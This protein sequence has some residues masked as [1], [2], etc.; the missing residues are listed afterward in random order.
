MDEKR[1]KVGCALSRMS[2]SRGDLN[3][4]LRGMGPHSGDLERGN[5]PEKND[6]TKVWLGFVIRVGGRLTNEQKLETEKCYRVDSGYKDMGHGWGLRREVS[7]LTRE[8]VGWVGECRGEVLLRAH[9]SV[10]HTGAL[11]RPCQMHLW[12]QLYKYNFCIVSIS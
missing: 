9:D 1:I 12:L 10:S 4:M 11:P 7:S 2:H 6:W 3:K 8:E 5:G